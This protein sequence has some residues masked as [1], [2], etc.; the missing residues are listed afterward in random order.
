MTTARDLPPAAL[1]GYAQVLERTLARESSVIDIDDVADL[2]M[3]PLDA[4]A[5]IRAGLWEFSPDGRTV[6]VS[7]FD[8]LHAH[9]GRATFQGTT[10]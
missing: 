5:L 1:W 6:H 3:S 8:A 7:Q 2:G 10:R 9:V 4:H